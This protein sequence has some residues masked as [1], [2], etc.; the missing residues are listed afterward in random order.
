MPAPTGT[1]PRTAERCAGSSRPGI[2]SF[3]RPVHPRRPQCVSPETAHAARASA[4]CSG[5]CDRTSGSDCVRSAG[6]RYR[7]RC[8]A[9]HAAH[10]PAAKNHPILQARAQSHR[11]RSRHRWRPP[12]E[13]TTGRPG[14]D[15]AA[16]T[17]RRPAS[18]LHGR[19][20]IARTLIV[21]QQKLDPAIAQ[22]AHAIEDDGG[23]RRR[24]RNKRLISAVQASLIANE[25]PCQRQVHVD[26][27]PVTAT[28]G[29]LAAT[30]LPQPARRL[31]NPSERPHTCGLPVQRLRIG[32]QR[33]FETHRAQV[34]A[35]A[36]A[37]AP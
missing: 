23:G 29:M 20:A 19:K 32:L 11:C 26:P 9:R 12:A 6:S 18:A 25:R 28:I 37:M 36:V 2:A 4:T 24:Q 14:P 16:A 1:R 34:F 22:Q 8:A 3:L 35:Q 21:A 27:K 13:M 30:H 17:A 31:R 10:R 33:K 15:R 7:A 5:R